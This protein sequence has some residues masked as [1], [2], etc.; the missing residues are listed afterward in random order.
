MKHI[1][2]SI[3]FIILCLPVVFGAEYPKPLPNTFVHDFAGVLSDTAKQDLQKQAKYLKESLDTEVAV[4]TINTLN[5]EDVFDYSLNLARQWGIGSKDNEIRGLLL[6]V[7][8]NDRKTSIRTSRHLE[9]QLNDGITGEINHEMG[10]YFKKGDFGGGLSV[11]LTKITNR[12]TE[13]RND[14]QPT[15]QTSKSASW[16]WYLLF[17]PI[18]AGAVGVYLSRKR[19]RAR[20]VAD[21]RRQAERNRANYF[22]SQPVAQPGKK[23]NKWSKGSNRYASTS[24]QSSSSAYESHSTNSSSS[25]DSSSSSSSYSNDTSSSSSSSDSGSSYSGGSDFGGGGSDSS[26]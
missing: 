6:L 16:L 18:G 14:T 21:R 1:V 2:V 24:Q 23:K 13:T 15:I 4:V 26:W 19:R 10:T 12:L 8:I 3:L 11:G 5:G 25:Y 20:A 22:K 7:V 9:G 17:L